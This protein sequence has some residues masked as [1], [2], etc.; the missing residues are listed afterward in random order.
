MLNAQLNTSDQRFSKYSLKV[1]QAADNFKNNKNYIQNN[2][3]YLQQ[4]PK[5]SIVRRFIRHSEPP[6]KELPKARKS[7]NG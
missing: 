3:S 6:L 5:P 4:T 7:R 1:E 2:Y